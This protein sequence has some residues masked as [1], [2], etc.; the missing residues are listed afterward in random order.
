VTI[1]RTGVLYHSR[2]KVLTLT[3]KSAAKTIAEALLAAK[4][5][6]IVTSYLGREPTAVPLLVSLSETLAI[7]VFQS[8]PSTLSF[9]HTHPHHAGISYGRGTNQVYQEADVVLVLDSDIPWIPVRNKPSAGAR[10]FHI[11]IDVLKR[12]M[13]HFHIDAEGSW[14]ADASSALETL[15]EEITSLRQSIQTKV[16]EERRKALILRHSD[17]LKSLDSLEQTW[18]ED[19]SFTV[20]NLVGALR[21]SLPAKTLFLNE[22][23]TNFPIIWMH[24]RPTRPGSVYTAG[25]S[26]LGWGLGAA[27]GASIA[28]KVQDGQPREGIEQNEFIC[29]IVGDGSFVFGVPS[30]AFWISR[31]YN[32]VGLH[33]GFILLLILSLIQPFLTVVLNNG[34]WKVSSNKP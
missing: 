15:L 17:Y 11:D 20:P 34:G 24:L 23:V 33:L 14:E 27:I 13:G 29:L 4:N 16:V 30:A 26:S 25:A 19:G 9:P 7:P 6:L 5:P 1:P 3:I 8:C 18:P 10:I 12:G 28:Q 32:T 21:E 22:S 2:T 31:K